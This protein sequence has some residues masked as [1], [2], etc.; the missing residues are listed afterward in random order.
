MRSSTDNLHQLAQR[1]RALETGHRPH[2]HTSIALD[3]PGLD[4]VFPDR[5]LPAGTLL[6]LLS[7]EEGVGGSTFALTLAQQ[8]CVERRALVVVDPRQCFYPPA[9]AARGIDLG[10]T[11]V[12]RPPTARAALQALV[13]SLRCPA[14]GAVL[15]WVDR[16][17]SAEFRRLQLAAESGGGLGLLM[18]PLAARSAPSFAHLRLVLS[19]LPSAATGRRLEI[20]VLRFRGHGD[21]RK[22]LLEI[23]DAGAL[24]VLPAVAA[25]AAVA[26]AAGA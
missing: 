17:A 11:I 20:D 6:E 4:A 2:W 8:A 10:R 19:P 16:L 24:R 22:V 18:R 25:P 1:I 13:Q 12:I 15:G 7:G 3:L 5:R 14:L 9:A 21:G 26:R 23:D